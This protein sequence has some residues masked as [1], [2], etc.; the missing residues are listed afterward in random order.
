MSDTIESQP[1]EDKQKVEDPPAW[2]AHLVRLS[3]KILNVVIV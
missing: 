3:L 2:S 1:P